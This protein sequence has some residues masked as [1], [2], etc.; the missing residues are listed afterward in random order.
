M[1]ETGCTSYGMTSKA[2][3]CISLL[4]LQGTNEGVCLKGS[5]RMRRGYAGLYEETCPR[6]LLST[7]ITSLSLLNQF[8][9]SSF[10]SLQA[11]PMYFQKWY[12]F[13]QSS[14]ATCVQLACKKDLMIIAGQSFAHTFERNVDERPPSV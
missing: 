3:E 12:A 2:S 6:E 1:H 8:I 7:G 4:V 9:T 5:V 14:R 10:G 11:S 13:I